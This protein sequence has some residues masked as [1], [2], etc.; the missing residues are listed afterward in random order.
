MKRIPRTAPSPAR[1]RRSGCKC[2][3]PRCPPSRR[4]RR[5]EA[6][7]RSTRRACTGCL[8]W[9][10]PG[11]CRAA[12][13]TGTWRRWWTTRTRRVARSRSGTRRTESIVRKTLGEWRF[14][15][16]IV[17]QRVDSCKGL[18]LDLSLAEGLV[19][20]EERAAVVAQRARQDLTG[21][22]ASFVDLIQRERERDSQDRRERSRRWHF[23][24]G[25]TIRGELGRGRTR[26]T[27]GSWVRAWPLTMPMGSMFPSRSMVLTRVSSPSNQI[28]ATS[29][30]AVTRPPCKNRRRADEQLPPG[31]GN[32]IVGSIHAPDCCAGQVC[33]TGRL[34]PPWPG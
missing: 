19:P 8:A 14:Y 9:S 4:R 28:W 32:P 1:A 20:H 15:E 29:R 30:P 5:G 24:R 11:R 33:R 12:T 31:H 27:S 34:G 22:C 2:Q 18:H 3:T 7:A 6:G 16:A 26:T 10:P 17:Y 23:S 21:A 13:G 25:M